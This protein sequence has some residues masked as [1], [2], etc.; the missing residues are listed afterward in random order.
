[1]TGD[2]NGAKSSRLSLKARVTRLCEGVDGTWE[3]CFAVVMYSTTSLNAQSSK[4]RRNDAL[5][6]RCSRFE[7]LASTSTAFRA[8]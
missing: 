6:I 2:S 1:V 7:T 5:Q 3:R 8:C 4:P